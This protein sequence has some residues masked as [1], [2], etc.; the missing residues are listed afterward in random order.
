MRRFRSSLLA[1]PVTLC[2]AAVAG[3]THAPGGG[4]SDCANHKY[5]PTVDGRFKKVTGGGQTV[6]G[7]RRSD[8]LLGYHGSD[9]L[10]GD[11]SSDILWGDWRA[12]GQPESQKDVI[13]GGDGTD[14]IYGSHGRNT[15]DAGSGND[16]IS[17]HFGRGIVDCGPGRDIYHVARSRRNG[18]RFRNCE[19]VEY[20]PE[21]VRGPMKPLS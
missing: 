10:R 6:N 7:T 20:R 16:V 5:W 17:V 8:E 19:K 13:D 4:C 12:K 9:T 18:Y 3:A 1:L 2:V 21:N 14:F 11:D 15:I